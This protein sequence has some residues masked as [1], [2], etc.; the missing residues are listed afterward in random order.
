MPFSDHKSNDEIL[1]ELKVEPVDEI[2]G[3][4]TSNRLRHITRVNSNRMPKLMLN[5]R[6]NGQRRHNSSVKT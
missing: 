1:E 5:S 3:R 6:P 4:Y 2:L